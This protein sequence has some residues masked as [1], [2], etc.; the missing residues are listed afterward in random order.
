MSVNPFFTK[1]RDEYL[2]LGVNLPWRS[3]LLVKLSKGDL[4]YNITEEGDKRYNLI[5]LGWET[6]TEMGLTIYC[7]TVL[8]LSIQLGVHNA[9]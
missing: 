7:V 1:P 5:R 6:N 2:L 9:D 8:W 3:V 4:W